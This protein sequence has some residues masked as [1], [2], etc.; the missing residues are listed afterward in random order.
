MFSK[1]WNLSERQYEVEAIE[2]FEIPLADGNVL[3]GRVF[4]P[5]T[6]QP[7]PLLLGFHPL[8]Q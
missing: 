4:R 1:D 3:V 6:D 5:K 7:V 2:D 8:Q